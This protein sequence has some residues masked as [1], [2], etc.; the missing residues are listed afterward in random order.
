MARYEHLNVYKEVY[1]LSVCL[2]SDISKFDRNYKFTIGDKIINILIEVL[3]LIIY[4][5][6]L[7]IL[8]RKTYFL[9]LEKSLERLVIFI[10]ITNDLKLFGNPKKYLNYLEI[11]V[12][13]KKMVKCWNR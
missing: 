6:N 5:N 3:E 12:K 11:L 9:K 1:N 10:N 8:N 13:V 2:F 4:I 7:D